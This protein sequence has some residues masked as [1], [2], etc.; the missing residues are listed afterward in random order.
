MSGKALN[1]FPIGKCPNYHEAAQFIP[2]YN[3]KRKYIANSPTTTRPDV[4]QLGIRSGYRANI[5]CSH[6]VGTSI[7]APAAVHLRLTTHPNTAFS[8]HRGTANKRV[9]LNFRSSQRPLER[10]DY[11]LH[12]E[13][14]KL[15]R[16][17]ADIHGSD[18]VIDVFASSENHNCL[19]MTK[20]VS[21]FRQMSPRRPRIIYVHAIFFADFRHS[22][23]L[24]T[25]FNS[26]PELDDCN[27]SYM[28]R[29]RFF[30]FG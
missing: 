4:L 19:A 1:S 5:A 23:S 21:C 11:Q 30:S 16:F 9:L 7:V 10:C 8:K 20:F 18:L 29:Q 6:P 13:I 22:H 17:F 27:C 26:F 12:P 3:G 25:C 15:A 14:F 28:S 24:D 2:V